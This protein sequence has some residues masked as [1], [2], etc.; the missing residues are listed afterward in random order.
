[1]A[2]FPIIDRYKAYKEG[3]NHVV[4]WLT[5]SA[6]KC[7]SAISFFQDLERKATAHGAARSGS[8]HCAIS[9]SAQD[10]ITLAEFVA[11]DLTIHIPKAVL[12][13]ARNV[14]AGREFCAKWYQANEKNQ[15]TADSENHVF[16]I[17]VLKH[18]HDMLF[19]A[20]ESRGPDPRQFPD[21]GEPKDPQTEDELQQDNFENL[22]PVFRSRNRARTLLEQLRVQSKDLPHQRN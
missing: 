18:V 8:E 19:T 10:L 16:F 13:V 3:T 21:K 17:K 7:S 4:R 12:E 9:L 2:S 6:S 11:S 14:I 1:M 5:Q 15:S 20:Q 22:F